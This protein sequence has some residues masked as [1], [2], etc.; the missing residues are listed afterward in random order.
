MTVTLT[1]P[2][3]LL[4]SITSKKLDKIRKDSG[5]ALISNAKESITITGSVPMVQQAV[6]L[7]AK[8]DLINIDFS[9]FKSDVFYAKTIRRLT[10]EAKEERFYSALT[11]QKCPSFGNRPWVFI[12]PRTTIQQQ[13]NL[14][15]QLSHCT[16]C[17]SRVK[18][19]CTDISLIRKLE[20]S[21][22]KN[23]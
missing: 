22:W 8:N 6:R 20:E 13:T 3:K 23:E 9:K 16:K 2:G 19:D 7:I 1:L 12:T 5:I 15:H 10:R 4:G 21:K 11:N 18:K 14:I 17:P